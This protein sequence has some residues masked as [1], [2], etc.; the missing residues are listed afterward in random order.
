MPLRVILFRA[1]TLHSL[2]IV[3]LKN[4]FFVSVYLFEKNRQWKQS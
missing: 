1:Q 2:I 3:C 4:F